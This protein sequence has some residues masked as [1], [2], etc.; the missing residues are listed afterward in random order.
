MPPLKKLMI[1]FL[2]KSTFSFSGGTGSLF[3]NGTCF[4][5]NECESKGG[6]TSGS[7]AAGYVNQ[8]L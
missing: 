6:T 2:K 7:C 1:L 5:S 3:R 8:I 4:T